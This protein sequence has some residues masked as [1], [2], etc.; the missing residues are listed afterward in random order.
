MKKTY[1]INVGNM[2][3][4]Q[5]ENAIKELIKSYKEDINPR[6]LIEYDRK[7]LLKKRREKI[8]QLNGIITFQ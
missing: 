3:R 6:W 5:A 4:E 2:T 8:N 7:Q 1:Y